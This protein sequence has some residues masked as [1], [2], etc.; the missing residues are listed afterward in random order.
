MNQVKTVGVKRQQLAVKLQTVKETQAFNQYVE[1][2][3]VKLDRLNHIIPNEAMMIS[4]ISDFESIIA[5]VDSLGTVKI[6]STN[7]VKS[8]LYSS[9]S[10]AV[11]FSSPIENLPAVLEKLNSLPYLTQLISLDTNQVNDSYNHQLMLRLYVQ[12]PFSNP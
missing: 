10:I 5:A 8:G 1:T 3:Q 4:V 7:P 6:A 11:T 2:N 9:V 12:E